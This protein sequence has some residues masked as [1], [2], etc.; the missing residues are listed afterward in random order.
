LGLREGGF[1]H[2]PYL[3]YESRCKRNLLVSSKNSCGAGIGLEQSSE[4]LATLNRVA[5]LFG[6][7]GGIRE[8]K[9]VAFALMIAFTVIQVGNR[10]PILRNY[11]TFVIHGTPGATAR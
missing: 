9:L 7:I 3:I 8:K 6:F 11:E 4:P 5:A 1:N 10:T 2:F